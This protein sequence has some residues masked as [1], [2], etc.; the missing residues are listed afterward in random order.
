MTSV[1]PYIRHAFHALEIN[2]AT[3]KYKIKIYDLKIYHFFFIGEKPWEI[4]I[5]CVEI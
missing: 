3:A 1:F 5:F 4:D 2:K